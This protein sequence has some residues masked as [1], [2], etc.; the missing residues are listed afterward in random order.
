MTTTTSVL[1]LSGAVDDGP[2][3]AE[4][5]A[6]AAGPL[7]IYVFGQPAPQGSK[8]YVGNGVM[9]ESSKKVKPWRQ[10]VV[11]A[12][13]GAILDRFAGWRLTDVPDDRTWHPLDG[14]L[15][16]RMV[17]TFT[18]PRSHYRTGKNAHLLRD[19]APLRPTGAPDL[20]KLA[21]SSCDALTTA[22][23]WVDDARC[24]EYERLAK[25]YVGEDPEALATTGARIE[26]RRIT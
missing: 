11:A 25:C 9:V 16:V 3:N 6:A 10:D 4:G 5:E 8:K 22:G 14:P 18:R 21:R 13:Q 1:S 7:V 26:I 24:C 19:N 23:T 20:D 15:A 12:A 17:F 2:A